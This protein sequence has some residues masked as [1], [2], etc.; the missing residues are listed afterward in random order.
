MKTTQIWAHELGIN[1]QTLQQANNQA[2]VPKEPNLKP[3]STEHMTKSWIK[4]GPTKFALGLFKSNRKHAVL[5]Q[6]SAQY[7]KSQK[8][9]NN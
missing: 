4:L 7:A 2:W 9:I 1:F 6:F 8:L 3:A 5:V